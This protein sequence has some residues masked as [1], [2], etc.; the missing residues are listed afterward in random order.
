MNGAVSKSIPVAYANGGAKSNSLDLVPAP[1]LMA[2]KT[3]ADAAA[4]GP[5]M[6]EPFCLSDEWIGRS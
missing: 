4:S 1:V 2:P 5:V 6:A 3:R